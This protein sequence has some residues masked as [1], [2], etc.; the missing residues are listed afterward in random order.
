MWSATLLLSLLPLVV[1]EDFRILHR[2][3][4]PLAPV[5]SPFSERG[6]LSNTPSTPLLITSDKL[7]DDLQQFA[8]AAQN[9]NGALYQVALEREGDEHEGHWSISSVKAVRFRMIVH[10]V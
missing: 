7:G 10:F 5:P 3:H 2:V 9:L 6:I 4:N 8:K 1:A